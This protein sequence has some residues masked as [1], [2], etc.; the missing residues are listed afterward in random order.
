MNIFK[1]V[2]SRVYGQAIDIINF[3][4]YF[5]FIDDVD[6]KALALHCHLTVSPENLEP[7][8]NYDK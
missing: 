8:Y 7:Y 6:A 3:Q 2:L 4:I 5:H 1:N